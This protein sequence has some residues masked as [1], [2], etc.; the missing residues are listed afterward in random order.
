MRQVLADAKSLADGVELNKEK[1]KPYWMKSLEDLKPLVTGTRPGIFEANID[2]EI[3]R[4]LRFGS[5][6]GFPVIIA[7]GRDA[8]KMASQLSTSKVSVLYA[9]D[10]LIEP[11]IEPD[12]STV[13]IADQTPME[14]KKERHDKWAEQMTAASGMAKRGVKFALSSGST[15]GAFLQ[16]VRTLITFG[17]DH[18]AALRAMTTD[19]A[20]ILGVRDQLGSIEIGKQANLVLMSGD[21]A[22]KDTKVERVWV[23]GKIVLEP[24]KEVKK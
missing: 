13:E 3:E 17:L 15:P 2:R 16:N 7:G 14:F 18:D 5:E 11:S 9:V 10:S 1:S 21:Y 4:S 23:T 19:A 20:D 8:Y 12:K 24:T 6:F 22:A